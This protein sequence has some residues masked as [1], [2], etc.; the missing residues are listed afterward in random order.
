MDLYIASKGAGK[1]T[2]IAKNLVRYNGKFG[3]AYVNSSDINIK[4][5]RVYDTYDLGKYRINSAYVIVDEVSLF[6]D[7]RQYQNKDYQRD[8]KQFIQWLR[9]IRHEKLKIDLFTQS[10]DCDK[11]I[12]TMCDN[13]YI[14]YKFFRVFTVWRK[15]RKEIAIKEDG[16]TAESQITDKLT[17]VSWFVPGS[18][19]ITYIPKYIQYFDSFKSI[20]NY[21]GDI[22]YLEV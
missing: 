22:N 1:S 13:I 7:N 15:L 9:G 14:G 2:Q 8:S 4:G 16:I 10:Y 20:N 17:F 12:R 6:Y 19:K 3:P 11:K 21:L 18:L 5:V